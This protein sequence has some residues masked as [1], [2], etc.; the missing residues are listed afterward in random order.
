MGK[1]L[2]LWLVRHGET[3][4]NA[5]HRLA[6]WSDVPLTAKGEHQ[7]QQLRPLLVGQHFGGVW[8]SDLQRA[9]STARIAYGDAVEEPRLR[10]IHFGDLEGSIWDD[11]PSDVQQTFT[12]FETFSP[13]GGETVVQV[14]TRLID[15]L[16]SLS[17][18]RH[19]IFTHGGVIRILTQKMGL[20]R[21]VKNGTLVGVNWP[22]QRVLFVREEK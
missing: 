11:V 2:E 17:P 10:E 1:T 12:N 13:P 18:E 21:F 15:F 6:G 4:W 9:I 3:D 5:T 16:G 7:A 19:L 14:R 22:E 8:T 20:D